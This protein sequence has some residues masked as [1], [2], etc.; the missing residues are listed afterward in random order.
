MLILALL[1]AIVALGFSAFAIV[2][3]LH[4]DRQIDTLNRD[5]DDMDREGR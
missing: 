4:T 5:L 3:S 1:I 2:T